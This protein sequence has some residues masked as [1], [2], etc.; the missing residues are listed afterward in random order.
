M[1]NSVRQME[2]RA[3]FSDGSKADVTRDVTSWTSSNPSVA[4]IS[5]TGLVTAGTRGNAVVT[6]TYSGMTADFEL[7][8]TA[9]NARRPPAA[10]EITGYV[11]EN[12]GLGVVD[13]RDVDVEVA[14]GA[15]A[16]R[17]VNTNETAFFRIGG[18]QAPGF[19][20]FVR[21]RGYS[22][23]RVHVPELGRELS[24]VLAPAGDVVSDLLEGD[25]CWPTRTIARTFTPAAGGFLRITGHVNVSAVLAVYADG[26]L[27][28]AGLFPNAPDV[29]L[30]AGVT[31]EL[32]VTGSCDY[33]PSRSVRVSFLRPAG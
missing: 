3:E 23:A 11:R 30:H 15:S 13:L 28:T 7:A 16:G 24:V 14:G 18:L 21:R 33:D 26:Q 19:D 8:V 6:A 29:D 10:D 4:T 17:I 32:R 9:D 25:V 1:D 5:S 20:L 22:T 27:L 31:Y 12:G 2:A